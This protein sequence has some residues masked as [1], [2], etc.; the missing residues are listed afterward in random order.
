[1]P[2]LRNIQYLILQMLPSFFRKFLFMTLCVIKKQI[3]INI[4]VEHIHS[5]KYNHS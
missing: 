5:Y 1:M 4:T 2:R 3:H